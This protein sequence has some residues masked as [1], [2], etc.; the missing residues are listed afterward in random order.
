M[1]KIIFLLLAF[2]SFNF[3]A[4]ELRSNTLKP[5]VYVV[6]YPLQYLTERIAG[7]AIDVVFP[8]PTDVD[9]AYWVPSREIIKKYQD[10]DLIIIN[11]AD[12]ARWLNFVSLPESIIV[13]TSRSFSN[14]YIVIKDSATHSHGPEGE[15]AHADYAFTTWI[16]PLLAV[17][18]AETIKNALEKL[19]PEHKNNFQANFDRLKADLLD[20]NSELSAIFKLDPDKPLLASH[21]VYQYLGARYNLNIDSLHIEPGELPDSKQKAVIENLLKKQ[22]YKWIIWEANPLK[23]TVNLLKKS[24][25]SSIVFDPSANRPENG[26]YLSVM[27]LNIS[28]IRTAYQ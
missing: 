24:G 7:D 26:D 27:K 4:P 9:P 3:S 5:K 12:Y 1:N 2:L 6:N 14:D 28:N 21:P 22:N 19:M 13:N 20:I 16:D 8:A 15:H 11:G 25:M 18:Q 10:A 23:E 17:K